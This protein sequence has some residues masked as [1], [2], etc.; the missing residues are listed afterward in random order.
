MKS[1]L[2][3]IV[4]VCTL[5]AFVACRKEKEKEPQ[6]DD[7]KFVVPANFPKPVYGFENNAITKNGFDLGRKLFFDPGLSTT[8]LISCGSCHQPFAAFAN[9]GHEVSH[10][11]DDCLGARNA[12]P[13]FNMA[14]HSEFMW[15]G[16]VKNIEIIPLNALNNS[17]EMGNSL[18]MAINYL[19]ATK[20]Y[21]ELFNKA[22]GSNIINSQQMLRA[23]AQFTAIL[24][25]A[26]S[27]YDK[28]IRA[29]AGGEFTADEQSGYE[30][31]KQKC[32]ACHKEPLFTDL[33]YRSNGLDETSRDIGR[34]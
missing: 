13:I 30:L 33:S 20:P 14:W 16:G 32:S 26:N 7:I 27:K 5:I 31:F 34:D 12:P 17:C 2:T 10:G 19:N 11:V 24:V 9:L 21:P 18:S 29:E 3:V 4:T 6:I 1:K 28:H 23:L 15:D 8:R 25:S 22:F